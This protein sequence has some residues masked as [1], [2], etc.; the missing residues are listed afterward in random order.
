MLSCVIEKSIMII[1]H[2][3]IPFLKMRPFPIFG[4]TPLGVD[5]EF[6]LCFL[7]L[8]SKLTVS[9]T[10]RSHL[11]LHLTIILNATKMISPLRKHNTHLL[12]AQFQSTLY[13]EGATVRCTLGGINIISVFGILDC[14]LLS[15]AAC[16]CCGVPQFVL[17]HLCVSGKGKYYVFR[18]P[19][20]INSCYKW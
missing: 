13:P 6:L 11:E 8:F 4:L 18:T 10:Q 16:I 15:L 1:R 3:T 19:S 14:V 17:R 9:P 20:A 12:A 7:L 2:I 5:A